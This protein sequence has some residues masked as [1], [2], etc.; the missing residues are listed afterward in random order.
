MS[1]NIKKGLII[2][3]YCNI[4]EGVDCP[5]LETIKPVDVSDDGDLY[6]CKHACSN[7]SY[8]HHIDNL[9]EH[10]PLPNYT[11]GKK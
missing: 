1:V 9:M 11:K 6:K 2:Q 4:E 7:G 10:C 5:Y 3:S 8:F